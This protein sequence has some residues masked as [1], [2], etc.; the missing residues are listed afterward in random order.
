MVTE[1]RTLTKLKRE[2]LRRGLSQ[3]ALAAQAGRLQATD[4][5]KFETGRVIPYPNQAKRIADVLGL[6]P[7]EL[8]QPVE[9]AS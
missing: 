6:L 9:V 2:R 7:D 8:L 1:P 3:T 5:S 4:I